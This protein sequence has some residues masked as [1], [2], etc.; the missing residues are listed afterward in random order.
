MAS[1]RGGGRGKKVRIALRRNRSAPAR[2]KHW[3]RRI[4]QQGVDSI[5][6]R[7]DERIT[8][9]GDLSRMRTVIVDETARPTDARLRDGRVVAM[10]GLI[11]DVDDG[12]RTWPCTI[13]RMLRTRRIGERQAVTVGDRVQFSVVADADGVQREGVVET[14]GPRRGVLTRTSGKRLHTIA[15]NVDMAVVVVAADQPPPKPH[16][17]D[18]YIVAA[19]HGEITPLICMNKVDLDP[20]HAF[21]S[22]LAVYA[23]LGYATLCCS[24]ITGEGIDEL[25]TALA[26]RSSVLA[27]QSGVG[28]S[29]LLNALQPGLQLAIGTIIEE[30]GKGRHTTT[31]AQLIKLD[32]GGYVVDTP[33]I[34]SLDLSGVPRGEFEKH[35]VEFVDRLAG[36][37]FPDCTHTHET[38]CAIKTAVRSGSI[39]P[40]RYESYVRMFTDP[41]I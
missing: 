21:A 22:L 38:G 18:R 39:R 16:L 20:S 33:G 32:F 23:E 29:S 9:K 14:V 10:R 2:D 34:R 5:E 26:S 41:G 19:H 3:T 1:P 12:E 6:S 25:R 36:C 31:T 40:E 28:K 8:P 4:R 35:F 13:R 30:L 17:I 24:A 27:G 37:K 15:A 11:A 7:Q